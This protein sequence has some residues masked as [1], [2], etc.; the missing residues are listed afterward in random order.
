MRIQNS[1]FTIADIRDFLERTELTINTDYQRHPNIW[2]QNAKSYFIDT[3]LN[4]Y[5]FP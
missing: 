3:I 5:P 4:G 1:S 2:P